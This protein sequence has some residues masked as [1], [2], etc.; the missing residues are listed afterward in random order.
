MVT[1]NKKADIMKSSIRLTMLALTTMF[2]FFTTPLA[3][4]QLNVTIS[5]VDPM[6][7]LPPDQWVYLQTH[8]ING[9]SV[10]GRPEVFMV[11]ATGED[12]PLVMCEKWQIVGP[13]V[14][15]SVEGNPTSL[16]AWKTSIVHTEEFDGYCKNGLIAQSSTGQTFKGSIISSDG[17]FT[18][19]TFIIFK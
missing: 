15:K 7:K 2:L 19:A 17:S 14:Y 9:A 3:H 12:L 8:T 18:N 6:T 5:T 10:I 16:P 13:K 1:L 11:N 4:A